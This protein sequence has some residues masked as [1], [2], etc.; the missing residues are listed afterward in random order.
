[1]LLMGCVLWKGAGSS[2]APSLLYCPGCPLGT[3]GADVSVYTPRW[4]RLG[5]QMPL[6]DAR[7]VN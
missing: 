6:S 4:H 1:M 5:E 3:N 7:S 2:Y